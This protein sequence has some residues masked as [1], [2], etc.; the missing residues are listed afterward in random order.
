MPHVGLP[1]TIDTHKTSGNTRP[2]PVDPQ[3]LLPISEANDLGLAAAGPHG[4][5]SFRLHTYHCL[6]S[7][8]LLTT[9]YEI[10]SLPHRAPPSL[11]R[12]YILPLPAFPASNIDYVPSKQDALDKSTSSLA[13][14]ES[15]TATAK[16][17]PSLPLSIRIDRKPHIIQR[18]DGWEKRRDWRCGRCGL[19]VGYELEPSQELARQET[20]GKVAYLL[21]GGLLT[22]DE[23]VQKS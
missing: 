4:M 5:S 23:M 1:S 11:D 8:L 18:E 9:P 22:T 12:A 7:N 10:A 14:K 13:N 21:E 3:S 19:H 20:Q 2:F 6:C 17:L 15:T 16:H